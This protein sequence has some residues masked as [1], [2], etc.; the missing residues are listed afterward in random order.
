MKLPQPF[1]FNSE[2]AKRAILLLHAYTGSANDVRML[3]RALNRAGY[4]VY[5]PH[6]SGHATADVFDLVDFSASQW[7]ADGQAAY[8]K[9]KNQGY[10]E[11]AIF[12]LS[13][14]GVIATQLVIN[15]PEVLA[16][17]VFCSP[18]MTEDLKQTQV[19]SQ[20][21]QYTKQVLK[22]QEFNQ[23]DIERALEKIQ[24]GLEQTL[25]S[26]NSLQAQIR[27]DLEKISC[28]F[29]IADAGQ[30]ELISHQ[31]GADL[32]KVLVNA[33]TDYHHYP[34]S[35]HVVT[36][37]PTR[38]QLEADLITFLDHLAWRN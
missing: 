29:F 22:A 25:N 24:P 26:I 20:F 14:G 8:E 7:V 15:N 9:L 16:G 18:I 4:T 5:A 11:I 6:L 17:G 31:S 19:P 32:N 33:Q 38:R 10:Q 34:E 21:V 2:D 30:D 23:M 27:Q 3:G 35:G 36:V 1:L 28:P 13:L 37:G 12:G